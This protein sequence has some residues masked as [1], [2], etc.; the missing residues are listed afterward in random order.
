MSGVSVATPS[1]EDLVADA[2]TRR[3]FTKV[4]CGVSLRDPEIVERIATLYTLAGVTVVDVALDTEIVAAAKRGI[5]R[6]QA[7]NPQTKAPVVMVSLGLDSDP[8]IGAALLHPSICA[9]CSG[10]VIE[11]LRVCA[12]RPL[13]VRA[14]ECPGCMKCL[15]ACPY[16][17]LRFAQVHQD[18]GVAIGHAVVAGAGAVEL[19]VAGAK[20]AEVALLHAQVAP[21]LPQDGWLSL[22]VGATVDGDDGLARKAVIAGGLGARVLL[23]VEGR[24]MRGD[25]GSGHSDDRTIDACRTLERTGTQVPLQLAGGT[26]T[27]T[28]KRALQ[29]GVRVNG[30][31]FGTAARQ[32]VAGALTGPFDPQSETFAA[33]LTAAKHLIKSG[34]ASEAA[35]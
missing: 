34:D 18:V 15:S 21:Y 28:R 3:S 1:H 12:E 10:C 19:H 25:D 16:G 33:A 27:D 17:A 22:S 20:D 32:A 9:T 14:P 30:I 5:A 13:A 26:T 2:L 24:P 8:H 23:Q 29:A 31:A 11:D 4:I 6:A 7:L 35:A